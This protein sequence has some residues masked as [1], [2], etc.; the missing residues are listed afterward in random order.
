MGAVD[1][2]DDR[3]VAMQKKVLIVD[4]YLLLDNGQD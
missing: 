4:Q 1:V 2:I 3:R